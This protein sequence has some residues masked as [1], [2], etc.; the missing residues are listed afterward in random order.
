MNLV[1]A[2]ALALVCGSTAVAAAD[3]PPVGAIA[4]LDRPVAVVQGT[5]IWGSELEDAIP[6]RAKDQPVTSELIATVLDQLIDTQL[7][8]NAADL[9]HLTATDAEIDAGIASVKQANNIDDAG[10]DKALADIHLTRPAYRD[11]IAK[12][13]RTQKLIQIEWAS[14][15]T[16]TDDDIKRAYATHKAEDPKLGPL[17]AAMKE[18]V[19]E[20]VRL[21]KLDATNRAWSK[22]Q[23]AHVH[24][25]RKL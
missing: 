13:L 23:R 10:L 15:I 11:E 25:E 21:Q 12:Q 19:R 24:I 9:L 4:I 7:V 8:L 14:K 2:A 18:V 3:K 16:V 5:P 20:Q 22:Q 6:L 17:D 1:Q